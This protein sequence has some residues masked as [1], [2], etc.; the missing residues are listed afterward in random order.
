MHL[1]KAQKEEKMATEMAALQQKS[2]NFLPLAT[3]SPPPHSSEENKESANK[4]TR[5]IEP[6]SSS[7]KKP[8]TV[9]PKLP[10][11]SLLEGTE[12]FNE[13]A[14]DGAKEGDGEQTTKDKQD[15]IL[16]WLQVIHQRKL[17]K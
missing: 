12:E 16:N 11:N 8:K 6:R 5:Q 4:R 13:G 15:E 1:T 9:V 7:A 14:E 2:P 3:L 17:F 10:Q